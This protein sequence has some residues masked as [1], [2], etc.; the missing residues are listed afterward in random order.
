LSTIGT[1]FLAS[2]NLGVSFSAPSL[3]ATLDPLALTV[4][5]AGDFHLGSDQQSNQEN[6]AV[7]KL[8]APLPGSWSAPL[9][10]SDRLYVDGDQDF[11]ADC[12]ATDPTHG[13]QA[14]MAWL[15]QGA[16][17]AVDTVFFDAE[18]HDDAGWPNQAP[19][20]P[21]ALASDPYVAP[22]ICEYDGDDKR[23]IVF[24]TFDG[25]VH[26]VHHDGTELSGWPKNIG[27]FPPGATIA[28]GDIDG[29]GNNEIVTGNTAGQSRFVSR[30]R[31]QRNTMRTTKSITIP[32]RDDV[33]SMAQV[34]MTATPHQR[35]W[36]VLRIR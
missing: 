16:S 12:L 18:W 26:V 20:F 14:A 29:D 30:G 1:A 4:D 8:D 7:M 13:N 33:A 34:S 27:T 17:G 2:T 36:P 28:V 35:R 11:T 15:R 25:N 3:I 24:G 9:N 6:A 21:K 5:P 22:A 32:V 10:L 23:E 19:G 31:S